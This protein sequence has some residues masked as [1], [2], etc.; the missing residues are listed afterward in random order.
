MSRLAQK[1]ALPPATRKARVEDLDLDRRFVD[2]H[3]H[4]LP[5]ADALGAPG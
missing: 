4:D 1:V 5:L 2:A 3:R